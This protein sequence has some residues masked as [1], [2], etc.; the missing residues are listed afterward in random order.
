LRFSK[1]AALLPAIL[2]AA[3]STPQ[4]APTIA[5]APQTGYARGID[6]PTD[7]SDVA[8]ELQGRPWLRFVAR[9]YRDPASRWPALSASEAR[10]LSA[11]GLK[12]VTVWEWRSHDPAYFS[13]ATG[14]NDALNATRQA[15]TVGQPPGSAIYFAVDFNARG[16]ALYGVDQY[17]RG[18]NAGLAAAGRGRPEYRVGVYGSGAVCAAIR[19]AGLAHYTWLSGSTAWEGTAG[20]SAWN[21]RQ[22]AQGARF[23]NLSFNHDA[24]EAR[25]DYGGFQ[26]GDFAASPAAAVVTAAAVVPAAAATLVNQAIT[27]IVPPAGGPAPSAPPAPPTVPPAPSAAA[28]ASVVPAAPPPPAPVA[29]GTPPPV[30]PLTP[31]S[32]TPPAPVVAS[33]APPPPPPK[34][35]ASAA[36]VA[37]LAAAETG[38]A[39]VARPAPRAGAERGTSARSP[40]QSANREEE[41]SRERTASR[42]G[43]EAGA[44]RKLYTVGA[45]SRAVAAPLRHSHRAAAAPARDAERRIAAPRRAEEHGA[46]LQ[47]GKTGTVRALDQPARRSGEPRKHEH[48]HH[49]TDT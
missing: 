46:H 18:V 44:K 8:A 41:E 24:N 29:T 26:L 22:A 49:A 5:E 6:L 2:L 25:D 11:L 30:A 33:A 38:M 23:A 16:A 36:E 21:I 40:E 15:Q 27:S 9:Y 19:G 48:S 43:R 39:A 17:F 35:G 14:Y 31:P 34:P 28:V 12:I 47:G 45:N 13:Y 7:A 1:L 20:Y 37:A 3:C 10:R 42:S 4:V 32:P